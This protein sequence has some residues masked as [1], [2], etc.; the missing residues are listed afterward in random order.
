MNKQLITN[1][2][3]DKIDL[4]NLFMMI[5]RENLKYYFDK[6]HCSNEIELED[7][8]WNNYGITIK[9]I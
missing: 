5:N 8:L 9:I 6:Y 1:L 4:D 7:N 2:N 3:N